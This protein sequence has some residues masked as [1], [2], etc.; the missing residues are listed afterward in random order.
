MSICNLIYWDNLSIQVSGHTFKQ[1]DGI[2]A[3]ETQDKFKIQETVNK[4]LQLIKNLTSSTNGIWA[5]DLSSS[6]GVLEKIVTVTNATGSVIEKEV[7]Y[8]SYSNQIHSFPS[9]II[10]K[11]W[12]ETI[13]MKNQQKGFYPLSAMFKRFR[14][15]VLC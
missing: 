4:T 9:H 3:N 2:I 12:T 5:G 7:T 1:L 15:I 6:L 14:A 11:C 8:Y 13:N 10:N